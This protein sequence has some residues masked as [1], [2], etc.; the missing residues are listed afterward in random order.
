MKQIAFVILLILVFLA[1][2]ATCCGLF[3]HVFSRITAT[4]TPT[5][6]PITTPTTT[7]TPVILCDCF[8]E[9]H[10]SAWI[11][12]NDNSLWDTSE[13]PLA[14]VE[15]YIDGNFALVLS[16]YPCISNETG[17]CTLRI[18]YPG[19]CMAGE[20]KITAIPPESYTATTA[21]SVK[22]YL[23]SGEFSEE[24]EFGFRTDFNE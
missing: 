11:D 21:E 2:S 14:E 8:R 16:T 18:W 10:L 7:P 9:F 24:G 5:T 19:E 3:E 23:N 12:S 22:F 20:Y 17:Q 1:L 6:T 15:F 4:P 13:A